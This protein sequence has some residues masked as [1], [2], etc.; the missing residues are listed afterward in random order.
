MTADH[1]VW[2]VYYI[3]AYGTSE[4][5]AVFETRQQ[6]LES[7]DLLIADGL[8]SWYRQIEAWQEEA[9][10]GELDWDEVARRE[11]S[12]SRMSVYED[13]RLIRLL[14]ND[15]TPYL[16]AWA[17]RLHT[18]SCLLHVFAEDKES[19]AREVHTRVQA[20]LFAATPAG[21]K[22]AKIQQERERK[23]TTER[24]EAAKAKAKLQ[25]IR[26]SLRSR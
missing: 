18:A 2:L 4:V 7:F 19:I 10:G 6:V 11:H 8:E 20:K 25:A 9:D 14:L 24:S 3:T 12:T 5:V 1:E 22:A 23:E 15:Q 17:Y 21:I 16:A 13:A 26:Q